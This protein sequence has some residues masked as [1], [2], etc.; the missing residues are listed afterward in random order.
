MIALPLELEFTA[1]DAAAGAR[2]ARERSDPRGEILM[3]YLNQI[4]AAYELGESCLVTT[5]MVHEMHWLSRELRERGFVI[6]TGMQMMH[7]QLTI[8]WSEEPEHAA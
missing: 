5:C 2:R 7:G 8:R 6:E 3:G 1:R 4:R